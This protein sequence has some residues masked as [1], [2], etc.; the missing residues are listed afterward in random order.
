MEHIVRVVGFARVDGTRRV[1]VRKFRSVLAQIWYYHQQL[2]AADEY[3]LHVDHVVLL[4]RVIIQ[5][6]AS[7][8][9][10]AQ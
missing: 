8:C 6:I 4:C 10:L 9:R 7:R 2:P 1:A 3:E 5:G